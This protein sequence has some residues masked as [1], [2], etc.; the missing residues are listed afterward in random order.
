[1][2]EPIVIA[3]TW[4]TT[5]L[6]AAAAVSAIVGSRVYDTDIPPGATYPVVLFEQLDSTPAVTHDG[7][8]IMTT[9]T[10]RV[11]GI[12]TDLS[13]AAA[14]G[15]LAAAIV[16]AIHRQGGTAAGGN[17]WECQK[18]ADYQR[19]ETLPERRYRHLGGDFQLVVS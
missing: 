5:T 8:W 3:N 13:A 11:R 17:V 1:M 6:K 9:L 12:V 16:A 19:Y 14:A 7:I 2:A 18:V 4:L 15:N 10:Y